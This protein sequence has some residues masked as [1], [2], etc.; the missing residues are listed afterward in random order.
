MTGAPAAGAALALVL[1][2]GC[3][4]PAPDAY[5]HRDS[6]VTA[7]EAALGDARTAALAA[8]AWQHDS[9]TDAY[10]VVVLR[11]SSVAVEGAA[12][13]L[14]AQTPP[15]SGDPLQERAA[16]ALSDTQDAVTALRVAVERDDHPGA[17][18]AARAL[19]TAADALERISENLG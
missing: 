7:V 2:A 16:V 1:L 11:A 9:A 13:D 15:R 6:V 14:T 19:T 10:A 4:S 18:T 8:E 12:G 17:A 5:D 3:G